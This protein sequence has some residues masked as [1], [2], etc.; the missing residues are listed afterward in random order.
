M[1]FY[2]E[3]LSEA[4]G[5]VVIATD[6]AS[7]NYVTSM[8]HFKRRFYFVQ[9]DEPQ[10]FAAGS[11]QLSAARTYDDDLDCICASPWLRQVISQRH[12]RW[13]REFW[14]GVDKNIYNMQSP[15]Q[16]TSGKLKIAFYARQVSPRRAVELGYLA[17]EDLARR[18]VDFELHCY[19]GTLDFTSAPFD[20]VDHGKL[21]PAELAELYRSC[22]L[23]VVFSATN[24]SLVPQEMMACGLAVAELDSQCTRVVFPEDVVTL[25]SPDPRQ[26]SA[27]LEAL[28][29]DKPRRET[30]A[31]HAL[32]WVSQ[33][34]WEDAARAVESS[35]KERLTELGFS[36]VA[37]EV[38]CPPGG[39][40]V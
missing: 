30:Q 36:D 7:V 22:D 40:N 32:E 34:E 8:K 29:R 9:D 16:V 35:I 39:T 37:M 25:V 11:H 3:G 21:A 4:A 26:M 24:Y 15:R 28:I 10:F 13:A 5:D 31:T 38:T 18:G 2:D 23:G 20:C 6:W 12:G 17:F 14:L 27:D 19:G 33:F 1:K